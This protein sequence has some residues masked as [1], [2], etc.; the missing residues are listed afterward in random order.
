MLIYHV[1]VFSFPN[2]ILCI[3]RSSVECDTM[4]YCKDTFYIV[5]D[6]IEWTVFTYPLTITYHV[7]DAINLKVLF[8]Y[9]YGIITS[10]CDI[11]CESTINKMIHLLL[12]LAIVI[13]LQVLMRHCLN[14]IE[15]ESKYKTSLLIYHL[16]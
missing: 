11:I 3:E 8:Y 7:F 12:L 6:L 9:A 5:T 2:L 10:H 16:V 4:L 14:K 1:L 15:L 13:I